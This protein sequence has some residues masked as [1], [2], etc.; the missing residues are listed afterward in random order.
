MKN[1]DRKLNPELKKG[2]RIILVDMDDEHPTPFGTKGTV[3]SSNIV[4]GTKQY[5]VRWDNGSQLNLIDGVDKWIF[6]ISSKDITESEDERSKILMDDMDILKHFNIKFLRN[7]LLKVRNSAVVNMFGA[8]P[9]LYS[10][11]DRL[12][13]EFTHSPQ[14]DTEEFQ[15]VLNNADMSQSYMIQGT[16]KWLKSKGKEPDLDNINRYIDKLSRKILSMYI[17]TF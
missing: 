9:L 13:H 4:L 8:S 3:L 10:G 6:D 15:E 11:K 17:Y 16:M 1:K 14:F 12:E 2:D 5:D 7:Y